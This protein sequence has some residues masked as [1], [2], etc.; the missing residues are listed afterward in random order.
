MRHDRVPDDV[1]DYFQLSD[2]E[3]QELHE[4]KTGTESEYSE[5]LLKISGKL[6]TRIKIESTDIEH[7]IINQ[8]ENQ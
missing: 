1:V 2:R 3:R 5:A 6:D 7:R 4:L 8:G